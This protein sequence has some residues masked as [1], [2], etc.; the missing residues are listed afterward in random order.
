MIFSDDLGMAGAHGAGDMLARAD[1]ALAAGCDMVLVCND[2]PAVDVLLE[3]WRVQPAA[4][5]QPRAA[6]MRMTAQRG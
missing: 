2:L 1:L 3:Q 5:L 4:D 6:R